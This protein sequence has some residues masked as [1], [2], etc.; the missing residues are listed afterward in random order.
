MLKEFPI[1]LRLAEGAYRLMAFRS[2][3]PDAGVPRAPA[4]RRR[5]CFEGA[6]ILAVSLGVDEASLRQEMKNSEIIEAFNQ[7]YDA[8]RLA[9]DHRYAF[10]GWR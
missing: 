8:P 10:C 4:R 9:R 6:T 2:L 1:Q 3:A 5:P 7:T